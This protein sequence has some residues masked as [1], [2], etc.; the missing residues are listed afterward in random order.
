[1]SSYTSTRIVYQFGAD[2]P[3]FGPVTAGDSYTLAVRGV[4]HKGTVAYS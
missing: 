4:S 3:S 2:Y 1:M